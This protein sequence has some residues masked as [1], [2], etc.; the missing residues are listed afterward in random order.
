M[1]FKSRVATVIAT[2]S[3]MMSC[4]PV[5]A[6]AEQL[7]EGQVWDKFIQN[8]YSEAGVAGIVANLKAESGLNSGNVEDSFEYRT[9]VTDQEY[10]QGVDNGSYTN[11][12][13]D[14]A[15]FGLPQVTYY[16]RKQMFLDMAKERGVSIAD[17]NLQMDFV[18][19]EL[20]KYYPGLLTFLKTTNSVDL[21]AKRVMCEYEN[22]GDQ[23]DAAIADRQST[24]QAVYANN[25]GSVE[26][27]GAAPVVEQQVVQPQTVAT[28]N[29]DI[30][31][32]DVVMYNGTRHHISAY[33]YSDG[34]YCGSGEVTILDIHGGGTYRYLARATSGSS[35][36]CY[37]WVSGDELAS[38]VVET[39]PAPVDLASAVVMPTEI[40]VGDTLSFVGSR[41]HVSAWDATDGRPCTPGEV[42]VTATVSSGAYKYHV[43]GTNGSTCYGWVDVA[44]LQMM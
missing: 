25:V 17:P 23:S 19:T 9:G 4:V 43:V 34:F 39:P 5:T 13:H 2:I 33:D 11:F 16:S 44:D 32:G 20:T 7:S 18:M 3:V 21:A 14:S 28:S 10:V 8:G 15:G 36:Y 27:T 37:G 31:V 26:Q 1:N 40:H 29:A 42:V 35:S 12:V 38:Y 30:H 41:H 6:R 24:A 22:P